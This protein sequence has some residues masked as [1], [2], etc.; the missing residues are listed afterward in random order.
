MAN[1]PSPDVR[2]QVANRRPENRRRRCAA[3]APRSVEELGR[4]QADPGDHLAEPAYRCWR[5]KA[6]RW[7]ASG[8]ARPEER[9]SAGQPDAARDR[10]HPGPSAAQYGSAGETVCTADD[11][12]ETARRAWPML[13]GKVQTGE[14]AALHLRR[15]GRN[16][17]PPCAATWHAPMPRCISIAS[18][19]RPRSRTARASTPHARFSTRRP[20]GGDAGI[21][22]LEALVVSGDGTILDRVA[23][24]LAESRTLGGFPRQVL[25][26]LAS[27]I[28]RRWPNGA[29]PLYGDGA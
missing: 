27:S 11:R 12:S 13:G 29:G 17:C 26:S 10:A 5:R 22:A 28:I 1:D 3:G 21:A 7:S 18:C 25:A 14:V 6:R 16:C 2:L 19:W 4:R 8:A 20:S 9:A 23:P 24:L 15:C